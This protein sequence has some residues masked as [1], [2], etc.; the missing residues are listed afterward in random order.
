MVSPSELTAK[1]VTE[2][3]NN[4]EIEDTIIDNPDNPPP[5]QGLSGDQ[6]EMQFTNIAEIPDADAN[7]IAAD[8]SANGAA[9][10]GTSSS[11]DT[12]RPSSAAK[13]RTKFAM[14]VD[15]IKILVYFC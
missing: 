2:V 7:A 11:A 4:A 12:R 1:H 3:A 13:L 14:H 5:D 10:A 9:N 8:A 15:W 6:V